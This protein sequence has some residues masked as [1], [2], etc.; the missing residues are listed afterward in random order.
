[1]PEHAGD[2]DEE[3]GITTRPEQ[4]KARGSGGTGA[5]GPGSGG[6][7]AWR[8]LLGPGAAKWGREEAERDLKGSN[9]PLVTVRATNRD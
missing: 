9:G 5:G 3:E 8:S 2:D 4:G 7:A 6:A 1:M